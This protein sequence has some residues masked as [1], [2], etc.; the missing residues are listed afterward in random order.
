MAQ[1][2]TDRVVG[3][4]DEPA[5]AALLLGKSA[6]AAER[7]VELADRAETAGST[8]A[9]CRAA[10]PGH[11][12]RQ[13]GR[14]RAGRGRRHAAAAPG[15]G[16]RRRARRPSCWSRVGDSGPGL[17]PEQ[18]ADGVLE[19]GWSTK[20]AGRGRG[21]GLALVGAG[22]RRHGGS[23]RGRHL[24]RRRRRS[25]PSAPARRP[26]AGRDDRPG[27]G[28]RGRGAGR[29]GAR[30][31][32]RAGRRVRGGRRGAHRRG[33]RCAALNGDR[34]RRPG[35][36]R[37]APARRARPRAAPGAAGGGQLCDVHRG[38]LGAGRRRWSAPRCRRA[39]CS[40][41]S[42][43]SPSPRSATKL[44]QYA[45]YR[46]QARRADGEVAAQDE[47]DRMLGHAARRAAG[48]ACPRGSTRRPSIWY[49]PPCGR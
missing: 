31:V 38:D 21:L 26:G 45:D 6:E 34:R 16:L 42:S 37:H 43:R 22:G 2:L 23:V 41:C 8:T 40:T 36:A 32:R 44:E 14:Q 47:V 11:R 19:R 49:S 48:H 20:A 3:A 17:A 13:P 25:S 27:A 18:A 29:R 33:R 24:G 9:D 1:Q 46:A 5:L 15:R 28:R 4:V 12:G 7:G 30:G 10:R 39:W 35:A